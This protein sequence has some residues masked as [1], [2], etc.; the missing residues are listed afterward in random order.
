MGYIKGLGYIGIGAEDIDAWREFGTTVLGLQIGDASEAE[1]TLYLR[2]DSRTYRLAVHPGA[3]GEVRY[4]GYEIGSH[5]DLAA[6]ADLL[7]QRGIDLVEESPDVCAVRR[8][9]AMRSTTDP[10][11]N[12]IEFFVGHEE[13]TAP[14]VSPTGA[15]FV[16]GD[17]GIGHAFMTC[18]DIDE[19]RHFYLDQLGFKLSDTVSL[20][21]GNA[22]YFLH[23]NPR[24]HTLASVA[25]PGAP[26]M[27]HH[28]MFQVDSL[29]TVGYAQDNGS[30]A[31]DLTIGRHTNDHM[32]SC[33]FKSPS[34]VCIEYGIDGRRIDDDDAWVV[35]HYTAASSWG[36]AR[37]AATA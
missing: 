26:P 5:Q 37:P 10:M 15:S 11:G 24:H 8:V 18:T 12:R 16:I 20:V 4:F 25:V 9:A 3:N 27:L 28:I 21:P 30:A 36:H 33:F 2:M 35:S 1:D 17:M 32:V 14:F 22:T 31:L 19:F 34:G 6:F 23:C 13:S 7:R 29:D